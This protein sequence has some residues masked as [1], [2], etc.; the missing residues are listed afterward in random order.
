MT[1]DDWASPRIAAI[2]LFL[3]GSERDRERETDTGDDDFAILL[4]ASADAA[5]FRL[6]V[7]PQPWTVLLDTSDGA[8][9]S[10]GAAR[11][12]ATPISTVRARSFVL[13]A[14]RERR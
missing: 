2:G 5:R 4:N 12:A 13:L 8:T 3:A 14:S 6:P 9:N 11:E 10:S 1:M 7:R